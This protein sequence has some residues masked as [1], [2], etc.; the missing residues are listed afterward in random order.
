M[1]PPVLW[2]YDNGFYKRMLEAKAGR[3]IQREIR[4]MDCLLFF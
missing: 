3:S 2:R 4:L 1:E